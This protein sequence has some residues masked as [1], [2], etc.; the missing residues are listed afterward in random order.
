[1]PVLAATS[2]TEADDE[3]LRQAQAMATSLGGALVVCHILPEAFR[4]RVLFPQDA[5]ID[6]SVMGPLEQKAREAV[7]DRLARVFQPP[8]ADVAIELESG[9]PHTGI[10]EVA[11]R[12]GAGLIVVGPGATAPRVARSAHCP[13]LVVRSSAADGDVL[14]ATDFSDPALPAVRAA[15]AEASRRG[16]RLRLLH[17]LELDD[18]MALSAASLGGM[19]PVPPVSEGLSQELET[20][21]RER[22]ERAIADTGVSGLAVVIRSR[23]AAGIIAAATTPPAALVVVGSRGR[24]G[25]SRLMLGSVAEDVVSRAPCSVLVVPIHPAA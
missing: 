17:S 21:A 11:E 5:G 2:L 18:A 9:T 12:T 14:G 22:L 16:L 24:S 23:P 20:D 25:L 4:I 13:I 19:M 3:V 15:A 7:A 6:A 8:V 10:L 1:G